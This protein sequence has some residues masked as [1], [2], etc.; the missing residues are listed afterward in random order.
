MN[1]I[2]RQHRIQSTIRRLAELCQDPQVNDRTQRWLSGKLR[3]KSMRNI[4]VRLPEP[5][6]ERVERLLNDERLALRYGDVKRA[7]VIREAV[8][9]GIEVI[10]RE[11][12]Q[13]GAVK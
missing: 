5:L 9:R 8:I 10:E 13:P 11:T 6:L 7:D 4:T 2:A 12:D 1:D 3:D